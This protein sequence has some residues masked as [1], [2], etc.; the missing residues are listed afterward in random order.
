MALT[1]RKM[2]VMGWMRKRIVSLMA[3][4]SAGLLLTGCLQKAD[5]DFNTAGQDEE[6]RAAAYVQQYRIASATVAEGNETVLFQQKCDGG[7]LALINR[8]I[9]EDIPEELKTDPDFVNDGRYDVYESALFKVTKSGKRNKVRR[10]RTLSEPENTNDLSDY[11]SEVRPRA[12][13]IREDGCILVLESSFESWIENQAYQSRDRY[14]VRVIQENGVEISTYEIETDGKNGLNCEQA[15]YL[16][17]NVLAVPQ[18][19]EILFFGTDGKR[20]FSVSAPLQIKELCCTADGDLAVILQNSGSLWLSV[21]DLHDR[22]ATVPLEVPSGAHQFSSGERA[23]ELYFLRNTELFSYNVRSG[24]SIKVASLLT[25]EVA[26]A[27]VGAFFA[28]T[29]G[30]LH[31]LLHAWQNGEDTIRE[32]YTYAEK[33]TLE[34]EKIELTL[35]FDS[36]SNAMAEMILRYNKSQDS[37]H[38]EAIDYRNL[39][40]NSLGNEDLTL[41]D[42]SLFR[43]L[44]EEDRLADLEPLLKGEN[45]V[46]DVLI[47][48]VKHALCDDSGG[49]RRI[50]GCFRIETM[51]CDADTVGGRTELSMEAL[52]SFYAMMSPGSNLYEP[53]Y[54]S[55]RLLEDLTAVN[56]KKLGSGEQFNSELYAKLVSFSGIQPETYSYNDYTS[57]SASM[58]SRIYQG[59][60]LMYRAHISNLNDLKWYDAFFQS[61]ACFPGWPSEDSSYSRICFDECLGVNIDTSEEKRHA[62]GSFLS[63]ILQPEYVRSCN[64]FPADEAELKR[65]LA[66]DAMRISYRT[67]EDGEYELDDDGDKIEIPRSS[68]YS[69]EWRRHY[70]YAITDAQ[71]EKLLE[72]IRHSV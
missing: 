25:L 64:A 57:N 50:A 37:V 51:A 4:V 68:W 41:M 14:Y 36:M 63:A 47:P 45:G 21:V 59:T 30:S 29:D 16:G 65:L 31:F 9:R 67:D 7:F 13:R 55:D 69:P 60:L 18:G 46:S 5:P 32:I 61:G 35:G 33:E 42:E 2:C 56:R 10:Y 19:G 40:G 62:A 38:V 54:T 3:A 44:M 72:L 39:D 22:T 66:E 20:Q 43:K 26:P 24:E 17:N 53:Y 28:G 23:D 8:K 58:E 34:T 52:R 6:S 49:L 11:Y 12:F 71:K 15:V 27:T 70:I 48:S 1:G